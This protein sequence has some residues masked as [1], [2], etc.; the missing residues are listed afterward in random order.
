MPIGKFSWEVQF[1]TLFYHFNPR[2]S[3]TCK[4]RLKIR[5]SRI[6]NTWNTS[7][8]S[9]TK[10]LFWLCKMLSEIRAYFIEKYAR[11]QSFKFKYIGI[12]RKS[13]RNTFT[14]E[15]VSWKGYVSNSLALIGIFGRN[16][17]GLSDFLIFPVSWRSFLGYLNYFFARQG[18]SNQQ[19]YEF[20]YYGPEYQGESWGSPSPFRFR[21]GLK[22]VTANLPT[23]YLLLQYVNIWV[24]YFLSIP[25]YGT[26]LCY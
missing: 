12:R 22:N 1:E 8:F 17:M 10:N 24:D 26:V 20:I 25:F 11:I 7:E 9:T 13:A 3:D 16:L 18:Q 5:H 23:I 15:N 21:P 4:T 6:R 19:K 2:L 14:Y